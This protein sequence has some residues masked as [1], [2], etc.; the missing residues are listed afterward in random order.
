MGGTGCDHS[1]EREQDKKKLHVINQPWI[2]IGAR[3]REQI[4]E[5]REGLEW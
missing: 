3:G 1:G 4:L 5:K 2:R